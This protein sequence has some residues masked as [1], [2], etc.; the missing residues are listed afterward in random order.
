M[1]DFMK[2]QFEVPENCTM[3]KVVISGRYHKDKTFPSLNNLLAE[4]GKKPHAGNQM[5]QVFQRVCADMIRLQI[6]GYKATRPLVIHYRYFEPARGQKRDYANIHSMASKV[7]NDALQMKNI[8]VIPNDGP[9]WVL[10]ETH[11]FYYTDGE[12]YIEVYLEE[13][14]ED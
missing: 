3:P 6:G 4:Y 9:E 14:D 5:K 2:P 10:N 12:P 13:I 7:F 11:D 8:E 1:G